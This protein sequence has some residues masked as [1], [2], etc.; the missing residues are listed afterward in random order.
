[1][2]VQENDCGKKISGRSWEKHG[3]VVLWKMYRKFV[4][5]G[6]IDKPNDDNADDVFVCS[7]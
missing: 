3:S 7:P 1:M 4:S 5:R 2:M 6:K